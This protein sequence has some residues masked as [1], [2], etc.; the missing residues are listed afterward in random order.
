[1]PTY[2]EESY[3]AGK[4]FAEANE[5]L[6]EAWPRRNE[7]GFDIQPFID[8]YNAAAAEVVSIDNDMYAEGEAR[9]AD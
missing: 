3:A 1:M 2:N 5:R 6:H 9:S 4:R 7:S 8:E